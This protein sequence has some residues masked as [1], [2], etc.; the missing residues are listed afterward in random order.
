MSNNNKVK[1]KKVDKTK[2]FTRILAF[3]LCALMVLGSLVIILQSRLFASALE[4]TVDAQTVRIGLMYGDDVT[5]GFETST[6]NGFSFGCV[7][8]G[9]SFLPLYSISDSKISVT[10]DSN[11]AKTNMTYSKT[12]SS[13][14]VIGGYHIE[15]ENNFATSFDTDSGINFIKLAL[16]NFQ[17]GVFPAYCDGNFRIRIGDFASENEAQLA[18]NSIAPFINPWIVS[19]PFLYASSY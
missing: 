3:V 4:S 16:G 11:L 5:V 14:P 7:L 13:T 19:L 6:P 12:K 10:C 9:S 1:K 15:L 18:L 17:Y 8:N 2:L